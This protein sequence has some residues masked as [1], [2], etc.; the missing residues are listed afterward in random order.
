MSRSLPR[1][2]A[3]AVVGVFLV[4]VARFYH[5]RV[6]FSELI[7][8]PE[9][10][11]SELPVLRTIP[12][13][14]VPEFAAYDGQFYAQL[15]LEPLLR[16]PAI[17]RAMDLA[18]YRTRRIL[19]S[20][21]AYLLGLGRPAWVLQAYALQ[22]VLC[23]LILAYVL[24]RW[25]PPDSFRHVALWAACLFA[26]G[27]M[28]SVRSSLLD[29][30]SLLLIAIAIAAAERG[31][32]LASAGILG[33][34]GLGRETNLLASV[35]LRR[36]ITR[37]DWLRGAVAVVLIALP[38]LLWQDY[39]WSIYRSTSVTRQNQLDW[40]LIVFVQ[41]WRSVLFEVA[42]S[43]LFAAAGV[44]FCT[45]VSLTA[46]ALYLLRRPRIDLPW[47]RVA[48]AYALLMLIVDRVVWDGYPGA[49][50]RVLLPLTVGFNVLL[51][52]ETTREFWPWFIA[53]NLHVLPGV[54]LLGL[55]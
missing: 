42:G 39:L 54:G 53:G 22:N 40:P 41:K 5:P 50:T 3:I 52:R 31:Y 27:L 23:W 36:P 48:F 18:P 11:Q 51:D 7:G 33:A 19:F 34:A 25:L 43:S 44:A 29:G 17:D 20:W 13:A 55:W 32:Q 49:V 24:T 45:V 21:T 6:G 16:D 37:R 28:W 14:D 9:G 12:H 4:A 8:L 10:E 1:L 26:C 15:A 46:Q 35:G 47:W 30:P 2:L 38:L